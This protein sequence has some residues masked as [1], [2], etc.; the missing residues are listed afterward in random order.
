[1]KHSYLG[2]LTAAAIAMATSLAAEASGTISAI[3]DGTENVWTI[4]PEVNLGDA[5]MDEPPLLSGFAPQTDEFAGLS[6]IVMWA[7][8]DDSSSL[9]VTAY[10]R[11]S[12]EPS[13]IDDLFK[14]FLVYIDEPSQGAWVS[15]FKDSEA[16]LTIDSY[17]ENGDVL[18]VAGSFTT[19]AFFEAADADEP[20]PDVSLRITGTFNATLSRVEIE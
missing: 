9:M 12:G 4:V 14:G 2:W 16:K 19:T 8:A 20:D 13:M 11:T 15:D 18:T 1:M 3:I 7:Q 17:D 6:G 10:H 5:Y